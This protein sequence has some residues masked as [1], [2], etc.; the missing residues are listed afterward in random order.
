MEKDIMLMCRNACA[1]NE[2]GS[3]IYKDAKTLKKIVGSKKY[4]IEHGRP[5]TLTPGKSER[6]RNRRLRSGISHSAVTAALQ[7]EDDEEEDE[8]E[9]VEEAEEESDGNLVSQL[10]SFF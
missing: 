3:Q 8:E 5:G 7:Y 4:E 6:I 2:P 9:E 10:C 1:F